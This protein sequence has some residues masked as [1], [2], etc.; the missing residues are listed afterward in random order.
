MASPPH[1]ARENGKK[2]G[3]PP[4]SKSKTTLE[5]QE[6]LKRFQERVRAHVDPLFESQLTLARGM[7]YL[8]R[9][10]KIKR[11]KEII[12]KHVVVDD[13]EEIRQYLDDEV[14][15]DTYY[16]ITTKDPDNKAID[17]LLDRTFGKAPQSVDIKGDI[18]VAPDDIRSLIAALPDAERTQ[19]YAF[20]ARLIQQSKRPGESGKGTARKS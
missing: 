16:Y 13:P 17:S 3:R 11:G 19:A 8:F 7:T 6:A 20:L 4:G 2:G 9:V 12:E 5:K 1:I 10:D 18:K 15:E 14:D